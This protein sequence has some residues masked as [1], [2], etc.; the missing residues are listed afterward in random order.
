MWDQQSVGL[1]KGTTYQCGN[2]FQPLSPARGAAAP[3]TGQTA[4][5]T[6]G[7]PSAAASSGL[8]GGIP[9]CFSNYECFTKSH[10]MS[11]FYNSIHTDNVLLWEKP[12]L[13]PTKGSLM[14]TL[15]TPSQQVV[16]LATT[17]CSGLLTTWAPCCGCC[18]GSQQVVKVV[19]TNLLWMCCECRHKPPL[20]SVIQ[21]AHYWYR[22][23]HL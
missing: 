11:A 19:V 15:R 3:A 16:S 23:I 5:K 22:D 17:G 1:L 7:L 14:S 6:E 21:F 2:R 13:Y 20:T 10:P 4:G 9:S 12:S 8:L 18:G